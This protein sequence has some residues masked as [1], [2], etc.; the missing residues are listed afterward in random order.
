M[1]GFPGGSAVCRVTIEVEIVGSNLT[2]DSYKSTGRKRES[3][4]WRNA[5]QIDEH[6]KALKQ[7]C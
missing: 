1:A 2:K 6:E 4:S 7:E 3:V 5:M